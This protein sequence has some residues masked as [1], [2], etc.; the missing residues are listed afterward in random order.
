MCQL[1]SIHP[2]IH[3]ILEEVEEGE[4]E[5][6]ERKKKKKKKI[7]PGKGSRGHIFFSKGVAYMLTSYMYCMYL[8]TCTI[9]SSRREILFATL[10]PM[11]GKGSQLPSERRGP[12]ASITASQ[13]DYPDCY[14]DRMTSIRQ[15]SQ[16]L[17]RPHSGGT[18]YVEGSGD[19]W[20][21][22]RKKV[23]V[24]MY[25]GGFCIVCMYNTYISVNVRVS[26]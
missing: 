15:D 19:E 22:Q 18:T 11:L 6:G 21:L 20:E 25:L 10:R 4:E 23:L 13:T 14:I 17:Q 2:S 12:R 7:T 5:W 3:P 26:T 1:S 8:C 16:T 24:H 9:R